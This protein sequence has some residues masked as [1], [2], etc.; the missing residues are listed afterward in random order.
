MF[1]LTSGP[2]EK[3]DTPDCCLYFPKLLHFQTCPT[4]P[5]AQWSREKRAWGPGHSYVED[6]AFLHSFSSCLLLLLHPDTQNINADGTQP[7]CGIVSWRI[8]QV[9]SRLGS[10]V[11]YVGACTI[12]MHCSWIPK[13]ERLDAAW[14]VCNRD[15]RF[16]AEILLNDISTIAEI[17]EFSWVKKKSNCFTVN[18][19]NMKKF[20]ICYANHL[21]TFKH[22]WKTGRWKNIFL[23]RI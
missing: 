5:T 23:H 3:A 16:C 12:T 11:R 2:G 18:I 21:S 22:F 7:I 1:P 13:P 4:L 10:S 17:F 19:F 6:R 8:A 14:F 9:L 15:K 20:S